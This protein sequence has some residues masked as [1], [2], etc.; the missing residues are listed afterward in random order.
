V[1]FYHA[2]NH[3]TN[4]TVGHES[5]A[6]QVNDFNYPDNHI[7][8]WPQLTLAVPLLQERY[9]DSMIIGLR[10]KDRAACVNSA[11]HL[12]NGG[13]ANDFARVFFLDQREDALANA[14]AMYDVLNGLVLHFAHAVINLEDAKDQWKAIWEMMQ[15]KGNFHASLAE[16]D[17]KYNRS[18]ENERVD[19]IRGLR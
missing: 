17:I 7:E 12:R 10:R 2:A 3:A 1:T 15:C 4:Y 9:P 11:S 5:K 6:G 14:A 8:I 16:W 19:R 13:T 18:K